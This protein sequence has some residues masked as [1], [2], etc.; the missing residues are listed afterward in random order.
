ME[1]LKFIK[2]VLI[3]AEHENAVLNYLVEIGYT[4]LEIIERFNVAYEYL[5]ELIKNE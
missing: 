2:N 4:E 5:K 1:N 3:G